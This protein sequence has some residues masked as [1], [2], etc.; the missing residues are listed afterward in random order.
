MSVGADYG[1]SD[2]RFHLTIFTEVNGKIRRLS[3][4]PLFANI[5]GGYYL[6]YLS[7]KLGYGLATWNFIWSDSESHYSAHK[8]EMTIYQ[9]RGARFEEVIKKVSRKMYDSTE[10]ANSL[11]ELGINVF[12]QR[13]GIPKI[14]DALE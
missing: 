14:K 11:R 3:D 10:G 6:G 1:G 12:D 7:K 4:K 9:L 5:Q 13:R 2:H 8:Y